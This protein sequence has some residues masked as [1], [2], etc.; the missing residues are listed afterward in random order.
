MVAESEKMLEIYDVT[1]RTTS[2]LGVTKALI[3]F[4]SQTKHPVLC[5]SSWSRGKTLDNRALCRGFA[6]E[7]RSQPPSPS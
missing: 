1:H 6:P 2:Q 5:H 7:L 4:S 3:M